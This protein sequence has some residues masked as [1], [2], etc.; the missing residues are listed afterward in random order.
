MKK[1]LSESEFNKILLQNIMPPPQSPGFEFFGDQ[2]MRDI[3]KRSSGDNETSLQR[4][5]SDRSGRNLIQ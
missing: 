1:E 2:S 5:A 3:E 4:K